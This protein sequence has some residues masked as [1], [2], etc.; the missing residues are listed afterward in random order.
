MPRVM[1]PAM[2]AALTAPVLRLQMFAALT[3]A[4]TTLHLWTGLGNMT[5][6]GMT[7]Q[8]VGTLGAVSAIPENSNVEAKGVT[9]TLSGIPSTLVS[10]VLFETRVLR[11]A[12]LW[13][14]LYDVNG[15][16][17]ADP[18]VSYQGKMDAPQIQD[19]G[20]TCS[21]SIQLENVLVDLNREVF[22]RYTDADQQLELPYE[23]ARLSLPSTTVDTGFQHVAGLQEMVT[24]WGTVPH[25]VNNI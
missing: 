9:L 8:G 2:Q 23:R 21:C 10:E 14:A 20:S 12:Q 16:L 24:Y 4:D 5:W 11:T 19:D 22:R 18:I 15:V 13:L 7:F 25:S 6:G 3:F 17:I 1:T